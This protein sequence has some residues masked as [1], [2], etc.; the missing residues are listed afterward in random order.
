MKILLTI[1]ALLYIICPFDLVPDFFAGWGW[2]DDLIIFWLMWR[3]F[4]SG[5]KKPF[6]FG[7]YQQQFSQRHNQTYN[8]EKEHTSPSAPGTKNPYKVL[9]VSSNASQAE[10]KKAYRQLANKYHPDKVAHLGDEFQKLAEERFNEIQEAY[11]TL[12]LK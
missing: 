1:L 2:L 11:Q 9:K 10:I 8:N 6:N 5:R 7:R 12:K 3:N 4:Y